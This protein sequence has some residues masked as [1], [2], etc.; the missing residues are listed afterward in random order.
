VPTVSGL[1][2][3]TGHEVVLGTAAYMSP[4]QARGKAV[5]RRTDMWAFGCVL[6]EMLTGRRAFAG[7]TTSD[8][9]AA[10]LDRDPDWAALPPSTPPSIRRLLRRCLEKDPNRRLRDAGDARLDLDERPESPGG[11][12]VSPVVARRM[13]ALPIGLAVLTIAAAGAIAAA[14]SVMTRRADE[15]DVIRFSIAL[16][17]AV[18]VVD[19]MALSP[20]DKVLVY[21]GI[22]AS[23]RRMLYKRSLDTLESVAIR[24]TDGGAQPFF[25]PDG[26]SIG[27]FDGRSVKRIPIGGGIATDVATGLNAGGAGAWLRDDTIVFESANRGLMRV[28]AAGGEAK[29]ITI[30]D[31]PKGEVRHLFPAVVP[32]DRALLFTVYSGARDDARVEAVSLDTHQRT[33]LIPGSA[34]RL[35]SARRIVFERGGSLWVAPFDAD[36]LKVTGPATAVLEGVSAGGGLRGGW[37]P[38]LAVGARGSLAY[39]TPADPFPPRM[40]LWVDRAGRETPVDAPARSWWYPQI[41]PDGRRLG[42]HIMDPANMDAWIYELEHGPL[43]RMTYDPRQ[44]GYPLWTPDGKRVVFWSRQGGGANNLFIRS[45]DLTGGVERLT[46]SPDSQRPY[47]W[48]DA[49]KLLVFE[50]SSPDTG[51]DIGVVPI[52]GE[53]VPHLIIHGPSFEGRPS[54]SPDGRWIAY[55]SNVT[56]RS[57]IYVQPFPGLQSRWQ[58]STDGGTSP[59]WSPTGN[60]VFYRRQNAVLSVPV[61]RQGDT[62]RYGNSTVL[63]EQAYVEEDEQR[64]GRSYAVSPD[65]QRFLMMR[66]TERRTQEIVV[67]RNWASEIE[68]RLASR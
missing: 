15:A 43:V 50:E 30:I 11:P 3:S 66:D 58:I 8:T 23:N 60:E 1:I 63:F 62:F 33:M 61:A 21:S 16:P 13:R 39:G 64:T 37:N 32:G 29:Q 59:I 25:S 31:T 27:F 46:T 26:A 53:R 52:D 14:I 20:D 34:A 45:A 9:I 55:E 67:I 41:S 40:L 17:P 22:D 48:A 19:V 47:T 4:E 49:G 5:D 42:L 12:A 65:G 36:R 38:L 44:D 10:I 28:P 57:E 24:G 35:L 68:R 18:T 7:D 56:G 2:A 54:V 6:Y 51:S